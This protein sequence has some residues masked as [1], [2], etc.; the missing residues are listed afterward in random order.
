[1][2]YAIVTDYRLVLKICGNF[3]FGEARQIRPNQ[4]S[5]LLRATDAI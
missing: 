4:R 2:E 1:M 5:W 3:N